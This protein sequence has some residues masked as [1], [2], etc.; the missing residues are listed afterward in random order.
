MPNQ[1]EVIGVTRP[2]SFDPAKDYAEVIARG[3]EWL[4]DYDVNDLMRILRHDL[5]QHASLL[6]AEGAILSESGGTIATPVV[7]VALGGDLLASAGQYRGIRETQLYTVKIVTPGAA[8]TATYTWKSTGSDNPL[9]AG[10]PVPIT[11]IAPSLAAAQS[12]PAKYGHAIGTLGVTVYFVNPAGQ[13]NA[14]S[15]AVLATWGERPPVVTKGGD[16]SDPANVVSN[17]A[18]D[19]IRLYDALTVVQGA[20]RRIREAALVVPAATTGTT[21]IYGEWTQRI[22]T[23]V[24]DPGLVD[25]R[26]DRPQA[27]R[28]QWRIVYRATDTSTVA[29]GPNEVGRRVFALYAWDRATNLVTRV[30]PRPYAIDLERTQGSVSAERL[31]NVD[32]NELLRGL[33]ARRDRNAHGSYVSWPRTGE[34]A[35]ATLSTNAASFGKRRITLAPFSVSVEGLEVTNDAPA[36]VEIDQATEFTTVLGEQHTYSATAGGCYLNKAVGE[37][38]LPIRGISLLQAHVQVGAGGSGSG[39]G[40]ETLTRGTDDTLKNPNP[41]QPNDWIVAANANGSS[42]Y[43]QGTGSGQWQ[44]S[45]QAIT[46]PG[47]GGPSNGSPYYVRYKY[48]RVMVEN[49]DFTLDADG[50][51]NF[52]PAGVDPVD[53]GIVTAT[54][55]A[56]LPRVDALII[57]P[58][59]D[60]VWVKGLAAEEPL[61]PVLPARTLPYVRVELGA[62][63]SGTVRFVPYDNDAVHFTTINRMWRAIRELNETLLQQDMHNQ[64]R[65]GTSGNPTDILADAFATFDVAEQG[66]NTGGVAFDALLDVQAGELTL[67]FA[68]STYAPA[69]TTTNLPAGETAVRVGGDFYTLPYTDELAITQDAYSR[70]YPVNPYSDFAAEDPEFRLTP[71]QDWFSDVG[72]RTVNEVAQIRKLQALKQKLISGAEAQRLLRE[73]RERYGRPAGRGEVLGNLDPEVVG[74]FV[75]TLPALY[76]RQITL[77]I[78]GIHCLAGEKIR[79]KFDGKD[80][81]LTATPA[82]GTT[83]GTGGD[84]AAV[85]CTPVTTVSGDITDSGGAFSASFPIPAS[86]PV[87]TRQLV[88]YGNRA[89]AGATW[90][91]ADPPAGG[92]VVLGSVP[93]TSEGE[94]RTEVTQTRSMQVIKEPIA[95]SVIFPEARMLSRIEVPLAAKA[96]PGDAPL[97]FQIRGTDRSGKASTPTDEVLASITR[98]PAACNAGAASVNTFTPPDPVLCVPN[99]YRALM[100]RSASDKYQAYIAAV[101]EPN[102]ATGGLVDQ[103]TIPGGIFMDSANNTDWTLRQGWD[104]RCKVYVAKCS[105]STAYLYY[106]RISH[107]D[108][109]GFTLNVDQVLPDGTAIDWE[110]SVDGV[111]LNGAGKTWKPFV[112]FVPVEV[113]PLSD[114]S[115]GDALDIRAVL[116]TSSLYVTPGIHE[117]NLSVLVTTN[118]TT[119]VYV[120]KPKALSDNA[121]DGGGSCTVTANVEVLDAPAGAHHLYVSMDSGA[122]WHEVTLAAQGV[123]EDGFTKYAGSFDFASNL[124]EAAVKRLRMRLELTTPNKALRPRAHRLGTFVE[125]I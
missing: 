23:E 90:N 49:V 101:G 91:S 99:E 15:W 109:T 85:I 11:A 104:L 39:T 74:S 89:A 27:Y 106:G 45:G 100:F 69:R 72:T 29:L 125:P 67:P 12:E 54:Y 47:G 84:T 102:Q 63:P 64:L 16:A 30:I 4:G 44:L 110:Y 77:T 78:E 57:R 36:D 103:Q 119:A 48:N 113:P 52:A 121:L 71:D 51:V 82:S 5:A 107:T 116:R 92:Y 40:Y 34:G 20:P 60:V 76:M 38:V 93:F 22:V 98:M 50:F 112:P 105:V 3:D 73:F 58:S 124:S 8:G 31:L 21:I 88:L 83:Q 9:V 32:Q 70:A 62:G 18:V 6:F 26:A 120:S 37:R 17:A 86:V 111:A 81:T 75:E 114:G 46:W 41:V 96:A 28:M 66:Y 123:L 43:A 115:V 53:G 35:R 24:E 13:V 25:P 68:A 14:S 108:I 122:H 118:R 55:T 33:L 117:R 10:T 95:Q 79:A 2:T 97:I 65:D 80:V 59:Q 61:V 56:Y 87:G 7:G 94:V 42:P 1:L 19:T